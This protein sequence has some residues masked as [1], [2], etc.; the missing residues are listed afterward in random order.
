MIMRTAPD[1]AKTDL[2]KRMKVQEVRNTIVAQVVS[3]LDMRPTMDH[4]MGASTMSVQTMPDLPRHDAMFGDSV[5]SE[6]PP[7]PEVVQLDPL[8]VSTN[9][10]LEDIFAD[11]KTLFEGKETEHN[12][13][14]RDKAVTKIRRLLKGDADKD[15]HAVFVTGIRAV[16]DGINRIASS[17]RTTVCTNAC[18]L[19]QELAR[20]LG[21][22]LDP[23]VEMMITNYIKMSSNTK[24]IAA[25]HGSTTVEIILSN[26]SY[27]KRMLEHIWFAYQEKNV[28]TRTC[29]TTWLRVMIRKHG[30]AHKSQIEHSGGLE[31][32]E[33]CLKRGF[34]DA[35]P[36]VREGTRA[37][38]WAFH[39]IWPDHADKIMNDLDPKARGQLEKDPH[40]PN[41]GSMA[42]SVSSVAAPTAK[43][44]PA[45]SSR[46]SVRDT[47]IAQRKAAGLAKGMAE[48][49]SSAQA[50]F[51]P[52]K[53][54]PGASTVA[55]RSGAARAG[56]ARPPSAMSREASSNNLLSS[57]TSAGSSLMAA[58]VRR[59][60][61]PELARPA[62]ADPYASRRAHNAEHNTL[63]ES[64]HTSPHK[65]ITK[66]TAKTPARTPARP[67]VQTVQTTAS[68]VRT[69]SR[70]GEAAPAPRK[71]PRRSTTGANDSPFSSPSRGDDLTL[72]VPF[73]KPPDSDEIFAAP[74]LRRARHDEDHHGSFMEDGDG[75][76]MVLPQSYEQRPGSSDRPVSRDRPT[77]SGRSSMIPAPKPATPRLM[78]QKSFSASPLSV[79]HLRSPLARSPERLRSPLPGSGL[80][81]EGSPAPVQVYE[82]PFTGHEANGHDTPI[83]EEEEAKPVLEEIP[84]ERANER[85]PSEDIPVLSQSTR[86]NEQNIDVARTPKHTKTTSNGSIIATSENAELLRSRRLLAS[87]IERIRA[88][89]LDAHGF[90]RVQDIV[91][92]NDSDVFGANSERYGELLQV[93][94]DYLN[95]P[96]DSIKSVGTGSIATKAQS[97][98]GQVLATIRA[99]LTLHKAEARGWY[100]RSLVGAVKSRRMW[101]ES[102]H[103]CAEIEKTVEEIVRVCQPVEA[104]GAVLELLES[105]GHA[106][107]TS[108][109][110]ASSS[111]MS[112]RAFSP[113]PLDQ[114]RTASFAL[115]T[116]ASLLNR[117]PSLSRELCQR[118][119]ATAV[120]YLQDPDS[121]VRKADLD[122]L[123]VWNRV[124]DDNEYWG[125][126]RAAGVKEGS[127]NL[128]TYYIAKG[129]KIVV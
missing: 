13:L 80:A 100:A 113:Q 62:T 63:N 101:E 82:D 26:V 48:R 57:Q 44:R 79:S 41:S 129:R 59:P 28:Q 17:L 66:P 40:N 4:D 27:N 86:S 103:I 73:T 68:H 60:R 92:T 29:A 11:M 88:R 96:N 5:M 37:G 117:Q 71:T 21:P 61:R 112:D 42:S 47:I 12:W 75:F 93:L 108:P 105:I 51:S 95:A 9:R 58:P 16:M 84:V 97:L 14:Q 70:A 90:R 20:A 118:L 2:K 99:M 32:A 107:P 53:S 106:A 33:K 78:S 74:T 52:V 109:I 125:T 127:V 6:A 8:Y 25:N 67:V 64:P 81:A 30:G 76:T 116:L 111:D 128:I 72:V 1:A 114:H 18:Q 23:I 121:D 55:G 120:K 98:K 49:P 3:Q 7:Q 54:T 34:G 15:F 115:V 35:N 19:A 85:L 31:L 38:F 46:P 83:A 126:L 22:A 122:F 123:L 94:L 56:A 87:G 69:K 24:Q 45:V 110:S 91:K 43:A 39:A 119:G 36:K 65:T 10:E 124:A 77:S 102:M 104:I 50:H 89:T